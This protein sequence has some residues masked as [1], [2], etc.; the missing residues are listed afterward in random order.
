MVS[1]IGTWKIRRHP[2]FS[3]INYFIAAVWRLWYDK[4]KRIR[5]ICLFIPWKTNESRSPNWRITYEA[6]LPLART[7]VCHPLSNRVF[8]QRAH[9]QWTLAP[10][11]ISPKNLFFY[12]N[13]CVPV[14]SAFHPDREGI[15]ELCY[16]PG[17]AIWSPQLGV[18]VHHSRSA[19][20]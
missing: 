18:L 16:R 5:S 20:R 1:S 13:E 6:Q 14:G 17:D 15:D 19:R 4:F 3:H 7:H 2:V 9:R 10:T 11:Y 8:W 12:S